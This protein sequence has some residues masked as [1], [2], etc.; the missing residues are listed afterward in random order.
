MIWMVHPKGNGGGGDPP[1]NLPS[2]PSFQGKKGIIPSRNEEDYSEDYDDVPS[3]EMALSSTGKALDENLSPHWIHKFNIERLR[4]ET[5]KFMVSSAFGRVY[6]NFFLL[7]SIFSCG[8]YIYQ[9]YPQQDV[10]RFVLTLIE[11]ILAA[12]FFCDWCL[13]LFLAEQRWDHFWSFFA[14]VDFATVVPTLLVNIFF[15]HR[16]TYHEIHNF[17]DAM[18]YLVH[19]AYTL[20]I[21]RALRVQKKL[22]L[23]PDEVD[24]FLYSMLLS[25]ITMVLFGKTTHCPPFPHLSGDF[26]LLF[27]RRGCHAVSRRSYPKT[28]VPH[29]DVLH[30]GHNLYR[31]LWGHQSTKWPW[32][33]LLYLCDLVC[34][35]LSTTANQ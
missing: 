1:A 13:S 34:D 32:Q 23:I 9:T 14:L 10:V 16:L 31:R 19:G 5:Q 27:H 21:L 6:M 28:P 11:I 17:H 25:V 35:R 3:F 18:N 2:Y 15:T 7:L 20:R 33:T 8:Q 22:N 24:R 29:M 4:L 26:P 12:V 30:R